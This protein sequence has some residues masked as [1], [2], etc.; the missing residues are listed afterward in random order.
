VTGREIT[1]EWNWLDIA[2]FAVPVLVA[3]VG[4]HTSRFLQKKRAAVGFPTALL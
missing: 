4:L 2:C 1:R 3:L